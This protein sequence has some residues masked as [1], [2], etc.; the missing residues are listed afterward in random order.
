MLILTLG[1]AIQVCIQSIYMLALVMNAWAEL[2][3]LV[4]GLPPHTGPAV[5]AQTMPAEGLLQGDALVTAQTM[6]DT[7][8]RARPLLVVRARCVSLLC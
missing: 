3:F 6:A 5:P 1:P 2:R 7:L 8:L 4:A